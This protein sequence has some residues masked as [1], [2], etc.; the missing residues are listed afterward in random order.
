MNRTLLLQWILGGVVVYLYALDRFD[1]PGP[2]RH[3]TTFLRYWMARVGY[4]FSMLA[5][6]LILGGAFTD[7]DLEPVWRF[8]QVDTVSEERE[9]TPGPLFAALVL[10]SL[11][12]HLPYLNKL[13][14]AVKHW[15]QRIGNIPFEVRELSGRIASTRIELEPEAFAPLRPALAKLGVDESWL[16]APEGSLTH[17]WARAAVLHAS[18]RAWPQSAGYARYVDEQAA[19]FTAI[20]ERIEAMS[21]LNESTLR[22]LDRNVGG[23][24][25]EPWRKRLPK[26]I[27]ELN[28]SLADFIAGGVLHGA[29]GTRQ[30]HAALARLGFGSIPHPRNVL[31]VHEVFLVSGLIFFG[32]LLISL[33][34]RRFVA[35][36]PLPPN[37]RVLIMVPMIY[38]VAIVAAIYPKAVWPFADMRTV[39]Y[40]PVA[41]YAASGAL[42]AAAAFVIS[43]LFRYTLDA[44]GN[45]VDA[46]TSYGRFREVLVVTVER[47]PWLLMVFFATVAIAWAADDCVDAP[48]AAPRWLRRAEMAGLALTFGLIQWMVAELL[49]TTAAGPER[50]GGRV[51]VMVV[52]SMLIGATIGYFIPHLYRGKLAPRAS[53]PAVAAAHSAA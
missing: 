3:T 33:L 25:D 40:R 34:T 16:L 1:T 49:S 39:G 50:P 53:A 48:E 23:A 2:T 30:R 9:A 32:M 35:P 11:L 4:V 6:F 10:T 37:M 21:G 5:L 44:P 22:E 27:D 12:P 15:F 7:L 43:L 17:R 42:A 28:Q 47:W 31:T 29:L 18:I 19:R 46:L 51:A 52:T 45:L 41:G 14:E 24:R 13:D 8:L 26:D 38:A 20:G 36:E